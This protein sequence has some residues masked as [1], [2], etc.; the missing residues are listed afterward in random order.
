MK[1]FK[2]VERE[3]KGFKINDIKNKP[4]KTKKEKRKEKIANYAILGT[5]LYLLVMGIVK[6]VQMIINFIY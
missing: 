2:N 1:D 4:E 5:V 3:K 6:T